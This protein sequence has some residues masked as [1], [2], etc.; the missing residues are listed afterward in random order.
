MKTPK[1]PGG[2]LYDAIIGMGLE[3]SEF[4]T[5]AGL[6]RNVIRDICWERANITQELANII[7]KH[8]S[9]APEYWSNIQSKW[10]I[11]NATQIP[12]PVGA[13]PRLVTYNKGFADTFRKNR[14]MRKLTE[15]GYLNVSLLLPIRT[16]D[17]L[18]IA[19]PDGPVYQLQPSGYVY[20]TQWICRELGSGLQILDTQKKQ[21]CINPKVR[22]LGKS[23][24]LVGSN[25]EMLQWIAINNA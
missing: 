24:R 17:G 10:D 25:T 6:E 16:S 13:T 4:E 1:H 22:E 2:I 7:A 9:I 5:L 21:Y 18:Y 11:Y 3:P 15:S 20:K 23:L 14:Y 19:K 12:I 8:I